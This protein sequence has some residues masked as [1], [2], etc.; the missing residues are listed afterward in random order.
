MALECT[1]I[2][3]YV[4]F[5]LNICCGIWVCTGIVQWINEMRHMEK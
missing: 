3:I 5:F 2:L 4:S 1:K